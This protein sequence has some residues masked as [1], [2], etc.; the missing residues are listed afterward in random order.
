MT[1]GWTFVAN[2]GC[3]AKRYKQKGLNAEIEEKSSIRRYPVEGRL[4]ANR[5]G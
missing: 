3:E 2:Y 1:V 5:K 4:N